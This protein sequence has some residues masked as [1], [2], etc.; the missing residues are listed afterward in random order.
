[1]ARIKHSARRL[2]NS[3]V[4]TIGPPPLRFQSDRT[5]KKRKPKRRT[6]F[7]RRKGGSRGRSAT[8]ASS[9]PQNTVFEVEKVKYVGK[10][11]D[12][13]YFE[14]K[15]K[16]YPPSFNTFET[17][18]S[19]NMGWTNE[20]LWDL[21][22]YLHAQ[23]TR[24]GLPKL[25]EAIANGE[26]TDLFDCT[27]GVPVLQEE[28]SLLRLAELTLLTTCY[29][30]DCVKEVSNN[31]TLEEN[32]SLR[33]GH[34]AGFSNYLDTI[35]TFLSKCSNEK[36]GDIPSSVLDLFVSPETALS[37]PQRPVV[38]EMFLHHF[39]THISAFESFWMFKMDIH[40]SLI[41]GELFCEKDGENGWKLK[42]VVHCKEE[43]RDKWLRV[44]DRLNGIAFDASKT[45]FVEK[46]RGKVEYSMRMEY[47]SVLIDLS[48]L[49]LIHHW[50]LP[51]LHV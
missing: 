7:S 31:V 35:K 46:E 20:E 19:F 32:G 6:H 18:S 14:V 45:V 8:T 33:W 44:C 22:K 26:G 34:N 27:D 12:Q 37:F 11:N 43:Q 28:V 51:L 13:E 16:H 24:N 47:L 3:R 38:R 49:N 36:F 17:L 41:L 5:Q 25:S 1:M 30:N 39:L 4:T 23:R 50:R 2:P 48:F 9:V 42:G 21:S 40:K 29:F 10:L 15:W